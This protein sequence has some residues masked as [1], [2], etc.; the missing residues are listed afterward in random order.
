MPAENTIIA[1]IPARLAATRLPDKPL[2]DIGGKPMIQRVWERAGRARG[3]T[4]VAICTPDESVATA[5]ELFGGEAVMTSHAHRSGTDR[6]A[7]AA[8]LLG[9]AEMDIVVNVQGDEPLLEPAGIERVIEL[10]QKD[11]GLPMSSL[12]CPCPPEDLDNPDCVKVVC[13]QN[14]DALYFS[15]SR[16]PHPRKETSNF[17]LQHVGLYAYRAGFLRIYASLHPTPL[18]LTESLEQLRVLESGYRIRMAHIE[19]APIG[20]DTPE[21]LERVRRIVS[22]S[23]S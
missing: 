18:E 6:L 16:V 4:R 12:S 9:L 20:V 8:Q 14:G 17:T 5:V 11:P 10:L 1:L 23:P 13:A 7:E 22:A 2:I 15:R 21:D 3:I 19:R